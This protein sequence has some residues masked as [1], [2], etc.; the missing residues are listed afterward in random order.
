MLKLFGVQNTD[1]R[2]Y[3]K[4]GNEATGIVV[5]LRG[6]AKAEGIDRCVAFRADIDALNVTELNHHLPYQSKHSGVGHM[7]GDDGHTACLLGFVALFLN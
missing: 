3:A 4:I 7:C 2:E 5:E 1:I 6:K